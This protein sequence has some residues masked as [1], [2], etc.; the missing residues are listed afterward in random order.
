MI[1]FL[2][3]WNVYI[4][5]QIGSRDLRLKLQ[6]KASQ[7]A[8]QG[9]KAS[10]VRDLREKLSGTV[11]QQPVAA[12]PPKAKPAPAKAAQEN[13]KPVEKSAPSTGATLAYMKKVSAPASSSKKAQKKVGA[14]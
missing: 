5:P 14:N 3:A 13:A 12:G 8:Y 4:E 6:K 1:R 11:S 7:Q 9:G 10:G 2:C